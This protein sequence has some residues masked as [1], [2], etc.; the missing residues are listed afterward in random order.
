MSVP[1]V[2]SPL[3]T[4]PAERQGQIGEMVNLFEPQS[5]RYL[6][7]QPWDR[8]T[9]RDQDDS[10]VDRLWVIGARQ[11]FPTR[12]FFAKPLEKSHRQTLSLEEAQAKA[13]Q[14]ASD[15]VAVVV[16]CA[17]ICDGDNVEQ[18]TPVKTIKR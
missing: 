9:F 5:V 11:L 13:G 16:E 15:H 10:G 14:F 3:S 17:V 1:Q 4:I 2:I 8:E 18:I 7:L 12:D 6:V